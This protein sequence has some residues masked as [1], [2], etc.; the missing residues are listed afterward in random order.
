VV[1][2]AERLGKPL[3]QLG[4]AE[5]QS[6]EPRFAPDA[7]RTFDLDQAM[8]RRTLTGTPGTREVRKQLQRWSKACGLEGRRAKGELEH[9]VD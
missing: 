8:A 6:V 9:V 1:A 2:L 5:L 4:L 7:L 3:D